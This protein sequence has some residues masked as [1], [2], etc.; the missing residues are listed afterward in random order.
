MTATCY[1]TT[2]AVFSSGSGMPADRISDPLIDVGFTPA[3][4]VNAD[5]DLSRERAFGDFAVHR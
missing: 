5:L 4:A 1:S 2:S 3:S